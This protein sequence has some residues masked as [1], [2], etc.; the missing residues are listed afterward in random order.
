MLFRSRTS[1]TL[2]QPRLYVCYRASA[3]ITIDGDLNEKAWW[4][5]PWTEP[6]Q[7]HQ[8]PH[9]SAEPAYTAR[10]KVL[11]DDEN[12]YFA[13]Q[14]QEP[15]VWGTITARDSYHPAIYEDN[16]FE[17]F[18][19]PDG[20][21]DE[22]FEFEVNALNVSWDMFHEKEYHRGNTLETSYNVAGLRHAVK[23]HGTLNYHYDEDLGWT[24]EVKWPLKNLAFR[25]DFPLPVRRGQIMR[26]NFSRVQY[27][28]PDTSGLVTQR[29]PGQGCGDWIWNSTV[30]GDLHLP[31]MWG[32]FVF[33]DRVA[34]S[35]RDRQLE[36]RFP[37]L[38]PPPEPKRHRLE[39]QDAMVFFP[40]CKI[41]IGPDPSDEKHSPA[42][43]R[44]SVV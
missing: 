31:E 3:P 1:G 35:D 9:V 43:D 26:V 18:L 32:R 21:G 34:G 14:M 15:N 25:N 5:A 10:A 23:V 42:Q 17:I 28:Q 13:A 4:D 39:Q 38:A 12:L 24:L 44:K 7:D 36:N 16:D 29:F 2:I 27:Y 8:W 37:L 11:Y 22:Y 41:T 19:D 6:F 30:S 40:P 20:D 33:S